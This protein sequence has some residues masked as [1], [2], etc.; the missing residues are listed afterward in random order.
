MQE[1]KW[2]QILQNSTESLQ[3]QVTHNRLLLTGK[4]ANTNNG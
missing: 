2:Q 4:Q 1:R 3:K